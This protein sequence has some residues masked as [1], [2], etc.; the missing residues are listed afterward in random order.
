M[1]MDALAGSLSQIDLFQGLS[2]EQLIEIARKAE[3]IT[4]RAG[5]T[6]VRAGREGDAAYLLVS[7]AAVRVAGP[8][9]GEVAEPIAPGSLIAEMAM[10]IDH[11]YGSTIMAS[12]PIRAL[13]L[14][15]AAMLERMQADLSLADHLVARITERLTAVAAELRQVDDTL[16][17]HAAENS[18]PPGNH[19]RGC[20]HRAAPCRRRARLRH[21]G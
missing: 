16:Q 2:P 8:D 6:I 5:E 4:F 18:A 10:L 19:V 3:R 1:A 7:G 12:T 9:L 15:R 17:Q 14:T 20:H 21:G 11:V 13:R